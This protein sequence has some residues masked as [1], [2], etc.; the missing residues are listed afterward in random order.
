MLLAILLGLTCGTQLWSKKI[1]TDP[2]APAALAPAPINGTIAQL[3]QTK[4][5][6]VRGTWLV[7]PHGLDTGRS[8]ESLPESLRARCHLCSVCRCA[9]LHQ[10]QERPQLARHFY[11]CQR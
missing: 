9:L 8:G 4:P 10:R 2:G 3:A 6:D 7:C 11:W 5:A 1:L